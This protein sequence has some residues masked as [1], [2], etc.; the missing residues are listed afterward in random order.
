MRK[1]E[2]IDPVLMMVD[3]RFGWE[4]KGGD[5]KIVSLKFSVV[6]LRSIVKP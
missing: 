2:E 6:G 5:C 4:G 1:Y 3:G